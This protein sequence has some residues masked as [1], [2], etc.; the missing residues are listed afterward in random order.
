M[1]RISHPGVRD[2]DHGYDDLVKRV[3]GFGKPTISTGILEK[4]GAR[5]KEIKPQAKHL[6]GA[7]LGEIFG[8]DLE[9]TPTRAVTDQSVTLVEVACANEFGTDRVPA[10]SFI[11]DWY[12]EALPTIREKLRNL[13]IE[14]VRGNRT[15]DQALELLAQWCVGSIQ[16][17]IAAG[18]APANADS[19][20]ARKGSSTPLIDTG[21]LRSAIS[22]RIDQGPT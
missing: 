5:P 7:D 22:Y 6:R 2:V 4:D 8:I 10:R 9:S 13:M 20:I 18:I 21:Q 15:R 14:V 17:R 1:T 12:D 16:A 3:F 11:R 19:T